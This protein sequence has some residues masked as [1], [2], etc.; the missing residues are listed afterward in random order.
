MEKNFKIIGTKEFEDN[1]F[2]ILETEDGKHI[3][4]LFGRLASKKEFETV[5]EA[6]QYVE[7][8]PWELITALI[9]AITCDRTEQ[10]KTKN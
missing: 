6:E 1:H 2:Q 9:C 4:G 8:R 3:I 10:Q 5:E 7:E